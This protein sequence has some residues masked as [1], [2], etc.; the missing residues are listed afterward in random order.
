MRADLPTTSSSTERPLP[1]GVYVHVPFCRSRCDYCAFATWTDR[2]ELMGAYVEALHREL[3]ARDEAGSIH[4]AT[5]VFFGGGTPSRLD[6]AALC[7]VLGA[8]ERHDDAE[9]TVEVNPEDADVERLAAYR[10]A[11]VTRVSFGIQS[12]SARVLGSLGR[13]HGTGALRAVADAVAEVGFATWNVDLIIGDTA[14][15][16]DDLRA[17]LDDVLSLQHAPPHVSAYALTPEPGTPLGDDVAR[18]PDDDVV[19]SRYEL[20]DERLSAMGYRFEEI[21]NWAKPGH[22]ARHNWLYWTGGEYAGLGCA[23]HSHLGAVRSWNVR[24]PERYIALLSRGELPT[25]GSESLDGPR[26]SFELA[27]LSLRT[28]RGVPATA[29]DDVNA[30]GDLVVRDG[31]H[32]VLTRRGRLLAT[33]VSL[34][35]VGGGSNAP[36]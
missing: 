16:D 22:E 1:F 27:S 10:E 4:R 2:D 35:L 14:E 18:H 9:V 31:D 15:S 26:A 32:V 28:R 33:A 12:T 30:L 6:T 21:S 25:A 5:S 34:H 8:I 19:A 17:T 20:V 11:G 24:T 7:G 36:R 3:A 29:F 13:R 23:A